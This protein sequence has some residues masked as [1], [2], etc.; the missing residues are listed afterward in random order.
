MTGMA[1]LSLAILLI[2]LAPGIWTFLKRDDEIQLPPVQFVE[3]EGGR[4]AFYRT[5]SGPQIV[6]IHGL[7]AWSYCWRYLI[8]LLAKENEIIAVDLRGFG[9]SS[10]PEASYMLDEQGQWLARGLYALDIRPAVVVGSSLGGLLA[11]WLAKHYPE[12]CPKVVALA[13]ATLGRHFRTRL[14]P[15]AW[16]LRLNSLL[17]NRWAMPWIVWSVVGSW[18]PLNRGSVSQ[19]LRPSLDQ[20]APQA[21][22][23]T[24]EALRDSRLPSLFAGL[25]TPVLL[26]RGHWDWLVRD[27]VMRELLLQL[28][29]AKYLQWQTGHHPQEHVP[30]RLAGEIHAWLKS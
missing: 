20:G 25:K 19:Y 22:F 28:P 30:E 18:R 12:L 27:H 23:S 17:L 2:I 9:Q 7:G 3:I 1:Y 8:P 13:P 21:F 4:M 14:P 11:L 16:S 29:N 15:T 24:F 26:I 5:G 10:K 6:L